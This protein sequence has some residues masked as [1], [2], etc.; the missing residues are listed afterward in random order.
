MTAS[1]RISNA[2]YTSFERCYVSLN[3][4]TRKFLASYLCVCPFVL[5]KYHA[6]Y[7][8]DD[9]QWI[10]TKNATYICMC[11]HAYVCLC[12]CIKHV[13][14]HINANLFNSYHVHMIIGYISA[15]ICVCIMHFLLILFI[16]NNQ[17]ISCQ[18]HMI[19]TRA[20]KV[21]R[22]LPLRYH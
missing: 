16:L 13:R 1:V 3:V 11:V 5:T 19:F 7:S 9:H 15:G 6:M 2:N 12:V 18:F 4:C 10:L 8:T 14:I 20:T 22:L 17:Y 21:S